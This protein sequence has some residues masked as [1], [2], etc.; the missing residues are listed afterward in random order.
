MNKF[1]KLIHKITVNIAKDL[2]KS[3]VISND[4][5]TNVLGVRIGAHFTMSGLAHAAAATAHVFLRK[6]LKMDVGLE[7]V[8]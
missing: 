5:P 3:S 2:K 6:S 7:F 1:T 8:N 4:P